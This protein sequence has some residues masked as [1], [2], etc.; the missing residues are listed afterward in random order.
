MVLEKTG[1]FRFAL[2]RNN[3]FETV[4][5]DDILAINGIDSQTGRL[6]P[7]K[8]LYSAGVYSIRGRSYLCKDAGRV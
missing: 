1:Q 2:D 7:L 8:E 3:N 4:D 6:K 5:A